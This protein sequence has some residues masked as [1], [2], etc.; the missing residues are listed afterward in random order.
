[1][2]PDAKSATGPWQVVCRATFPDRKASNA[3]AE[4]CAAGE[5]CLLC[6]LA[7]GCVENV[8]GHAKAQTSCH[9]S[10]WPGHAAHT[11]G[12]TGR[13]A[14]QLAPGQ[15]HVHQGQGGAETSGKARLSQEISFRLDLLHKTVSGK[16]PGLKPTE[17]KGSQRKIP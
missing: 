2:Y 7:K 10:G 13:F 3:S 9:G 6:A 15:T 16:G 8:E 11:P 14:H 12:R 4:A 1:M 5:C 17:A